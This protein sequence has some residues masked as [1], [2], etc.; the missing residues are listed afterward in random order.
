MFLMRFDL[1]SPTA[2]ATG[3][4]YAAALEMAAWAETRG[5]VSVA[6][7]EHHGAEDGYL[8][9][10][11]VMAGAMA[12][13]TTTVP[14]MVA[15]LILPLYDPVRLAEELVVLDVLSGGRVMHVAAVGY[16][17][18][19]YEMHGVDFR[20]RGKLADEALPVLLAAKAG[21]PFERGGRTFRVT[22]APV[23]PGGPMVA[24]G[25][26]SAAA[27]RR[28]GRHGIPFFAQGGPADLEQ[29]Y[30]DACAEAGRE[31][32]MCMIPPL[33]LPTTCFVADDVDRA[34]AELGSYLL[35]DARSYAAW[36]EGNSHTA[37]LSFA[38]TVD[39]LR[40]EGRSHRI[41][42]VDEAVERM[43]GGELLQ[44][45]PLVGGLPPEVAWPYLETVADRV[46]PA[47]VGG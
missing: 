44:L 16:R 37:S 19:E 22:P 4:L 32:G 18:E 11:M 33:D 28:A 42:S 38:S 30:L 23:T 26:G 24:W 9:S 47:A 7:C 43:R 14:V 10:P 31:P 21:E 12:A 6:V 25:G 3:G 2:G 27:A 29:V 15:A 5:C 41:L 35:H 1:R 39:E 17:P 13:R 45:H 46:V 20:R 36:N 40:A 8:P 34:W